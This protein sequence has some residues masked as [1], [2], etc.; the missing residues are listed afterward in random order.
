[1][2]PLQRILG[3]EGERPADHLIDNDAEGVEIGA[4]ID[5][6]VHPPGLLGRDVGEI[7]PRRVAADLVA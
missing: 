5:R 3:R 6:L 7:A 2:H 4:M 1:M